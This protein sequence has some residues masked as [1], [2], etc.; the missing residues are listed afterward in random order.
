MRVATCCCAYLS[1]A[2]AGKQTYK[3][4]AKGA[5]LRESPSQMPGWSR[6]DAGAAF[7]AAGAG[8]AGA[9]AASA[10]AVLPCSPAAMGPVPRHWEHT[11]ELA[12]YVE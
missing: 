10:V 12:L 3:L 11:H 5:G 4:S 2:G 6:R 7:N 1:H 9:G 8:A